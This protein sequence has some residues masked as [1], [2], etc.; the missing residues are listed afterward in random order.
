MPP[1]VEQNISEIT[2][3][4][5]TDARS[6]L[7]RVDSRLPTPVPRRT[8]GRVYGDGSGSD[9]VFANL[10]AKP[11]SGEKLEEHPP[12]RFDIGLKVYVVL[13]ISPRHMNR[14]RQTRRLHTGKQQFSL[15]VLGGQMKYMLK[16]YL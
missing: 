6:I 10:S 16:V 14:L 9:G 12:V 3:S 13:T 8:T 1:T 2:T 15:L 5:L 11:E 4:S 7:S